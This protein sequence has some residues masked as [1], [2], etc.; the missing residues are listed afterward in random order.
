[1][2]FHTAIH[3]SLELAW[4]IF[5]LVWLVA[6]FSASRAIKRQSWWSRALTIAV[7]AVPYYLLFTNRLSYGP[8]AW[9]FVPDEPWVLVPGV[10]LTHAGIALAIWAR[11]VLGK[12]WSAMVTIKEGHRL[13]RNGP[14]S[15][16]RHPIYSGLLLAVLGTALV[17]GEVRGLV[18]AVIGFTAWLVKSRTEEGF[19]M[20]EFGPEYEEYR[21]HTRALVPFIL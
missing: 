15:A 8:L 19:L 13:V 11:I 7:G 16:V 9:R 21:R 14:Y 20:K 18:A 10:V 4:V 17:V 2:P 6:A 1:M 5:L 3:R 12:N